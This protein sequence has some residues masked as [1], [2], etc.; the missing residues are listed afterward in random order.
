M[1]K[2]IFA[3]ISLLILIFTLSLSTANAWSAPFQLSTSAAPEFGFT[4]P[5]INIDCP[6]GI[7]S[8][9]GRRDECRYP[10]IKRGPMLTESF[11]KAGTEFPWDTDGSVVSE[12]LLL[13][14]LGL[15]YKI[16]VPGTS[17]QLLVRSYENTN[18]NYTAPFTI[19]MNLRGGGPGSGP[20][21]GTTL[22]QGHEAIDMIADT[23]FCNTKTTVSTSTPAIQFWS[24]TNNTEADVLARGI[25]LRGGN[26]QPGMILVST[27]QYGNAVWATPKLESNGT[28][29]F[30]YDSPSPVVDGQTVCR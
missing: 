5:T 9:S 1:K 22:P 15:F 4:F 16:F 27:D 23:N 20:E 17:G 19:D 29:S 14:P 11:F 18:L 26:P 3:T 2:Q 12:D 6:F 13:S 10:Q 28:I 7:Y 25:Q 21:S 8:L 24:T 30:T